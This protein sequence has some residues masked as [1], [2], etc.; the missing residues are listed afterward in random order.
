[1]ITQMKGNDLNFKKGPPLPPNFTA[2]GNASFGGQYMPPGGAGPIIVGPKK[3][4]EM[5]AGNDDDFWYG[6]KKDKRLGRLA[7]KVRSPSSS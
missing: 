6:D 3:V 1:M 4:L 7:L 2:G 5:S